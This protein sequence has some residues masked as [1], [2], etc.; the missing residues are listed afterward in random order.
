MRK[1]LFRVDSVAIIMLYVMCERDPFIFI[2]MC[3]LYTFEHICGNGHHYIP[4]FLDEGT[5]QRVKSLI[6][7]FH[8]VWFGSEMSQRPFAL[9]KVSLLACGASVG[10]LPCWKEGRP[11]EAYP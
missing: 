5:K 6:V 4:F 9:S 10:G 1:K 8:H 11:W 7:I 2:C 3:I